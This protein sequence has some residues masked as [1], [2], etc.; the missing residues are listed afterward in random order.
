MY[1]TCALAMLI[2][3]ASLI[4][5][6]PSRPGPIVADV[7]IAPSTARTGDSITARISVTNRGL[8]VHIDSITYRDTVLSGDDA[9]ERCR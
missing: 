1:R 5:C 9:G 2:T 6:G 3:L 7:S 4:G 8:E